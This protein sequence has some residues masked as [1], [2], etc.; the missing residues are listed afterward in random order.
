MLCLA[1]SLSLPLAR[2]LALHLGEWS[3]QLPSSLMHMSTSIPHL[4][5]PARFSPRA[6]SAWAYISKCCSGWWVGGMRLL[7]F[8]AQY[9]NL[10]PYASVLSALQCVMFSMLSLASVSDVWR[11]GHCK[12]RLRPQS[13][14]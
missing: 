1:H 13:M 5:G 2:A 10:N 7:L 3:G 11:I 8:S 9:S 12:S 6:G 14:A 4:M